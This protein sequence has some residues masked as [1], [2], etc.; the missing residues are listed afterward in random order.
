MLLNDLMKMKKKVSIIIKKNKISALIYLVL[1]FSGCDAGCH[2]CFRRASTF[3][4]D[5]SVYAPKMIQNSCRCN[6][7]HCCHC[8]AR[9]SW[10]LWCWLANKKKGDKNPDS[11]NIPNNANSQDSAI[12]S[13]VNASNPLESN[14]NK[15]C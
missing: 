7:C 15:K 3:V 10:C 5:K 2:N 11:N 4:F 12:N 13:V 9:C 8:G 14:N 1:F 6:C